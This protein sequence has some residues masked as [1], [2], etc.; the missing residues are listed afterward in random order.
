MTD[1]YLL[2][3]ASWTVILPLRYHF[4][5]FRLSVTISLQYTLSL[6]YHCFILSHYATKSIFFHSM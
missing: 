6:H 2:M 3:F 4:K 1:A 5:S